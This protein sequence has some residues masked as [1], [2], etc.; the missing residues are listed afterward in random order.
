MRLVFVHYVIA[1][2]GSAQDMHN[3]VR[4]AEEL[5]HEVVL[6]GSANGSPFNYSTEISRSDALVFI[7]EGMPVLQYG[8]NLDLTRLIAQVPRERR[9]VIDCDGRYNDA[10]TFGGDRNHPNAALSARWI[11]LCDSLSDKIVQPTFHPR[12]PRAGTFFFHGYNP[13]W[14][15]P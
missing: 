5:G 3:Y 10:I 8:D 7:L 1:N 13:D 4:V 6:Y 11:E 2:K 15:V 9:V 14:E 12:Q